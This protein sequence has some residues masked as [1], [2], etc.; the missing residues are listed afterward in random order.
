MFQT[1][2][3]FLQA[4]LGTSACVSIAGATPFVLAGPRHAA[5]RRGERDT[6]LVVLQLSGGNDGLNTIVPHGDDEY[7]RQRTTL[8]LPTRD[9]HGIDS[10][11]GFH[12]RMGALR[13]LYHEGSLGI[14]QGVGYPDSSRD[15]DVAMQAWYTADPLRP[16]QRTGWLGRMADEVWDPEE[17]DIPAMFVG[18]IARPKILNAERT[19]VPTVRSVDELVGAAPASPT[20]A[21]DGDDSLLGFVRRTTARAGEARA[22]LRDVVAE[23]DATGDYPAY[24]LARDLRTVA[25]LIRADLGI[26]VFLTELGGDG[27]GGF[28]NH[29]NQLDNHAALLHQLSESV[30]AFVRDLQRAKRFDDVL[31]MTFSEFGRTLAENGRRGTGHGEAAPVLLAGSRLRGGLTGE[32]PSLTDLREGA[33]KFHTDLR[34]VYATALESWLGYDSEAVLG[35]KFAPLDVLR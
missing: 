6:V 35:G 33:P 17:T 15:H 11:L 22:A 4:A 8:R 31:L 27:F 1:R 21:G 13:R 12:P 25:Q 34:R 29:A 10:Y 5:R 3:E 23:S 16:E 32:H 19:L 24:G 14:V 30:A 18:P 2:R 9:L 28:D 26:R 7:G 20:A